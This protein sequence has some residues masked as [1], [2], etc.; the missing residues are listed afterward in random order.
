MPAKS[1][2]GPGHKRKDV[3]GRQAI[4]PIEI[5]PTATITMGHRKLESHSSTTPP[6]FRDELLSGP[7]GFD[8]KLT[9]YLESPRRYFGSNA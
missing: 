5:T 6:E 9:E 3:T 1:N 4:S 8:G 7:K 2:S